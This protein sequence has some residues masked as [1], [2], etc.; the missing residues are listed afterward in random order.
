MSEPILPL[1]TW[2]EGIDQPD[3]VFNDLSNRLEILNGLVIS[4]SVSAQPGSPADGDIYILGDAPSGAQWSSFDEYDLAI[5]RDGTWYAFAPSEGILVNRAGSMVTWDG[6]GYVAVGGGGA[7]GVS[8]PGT[9]TNNSLPRWDGAGGDSIKN[10]GVLVTDND[11]ISGYAADINRQTGSTYTLQ[12]SDKGKV[13]EIANAGSV[14][15]T[16][17]NS[18]PKGFACTVIQDGA[19]QVT[20]SAASGASLKNRQSHS[21]S[22]GNGAF[23]MLYVSSNS[24]ANASWMLG[25]DTAA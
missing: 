4:D 3:L 8:G 25:G 18:L 13:I 6:A 15:L 23:T 21:K 2:P 9:S 1:P 20:F 16:L 24:G 14:T 17:P 19:G 5:Y 10:S 7:G 11:E 22:A 12:A